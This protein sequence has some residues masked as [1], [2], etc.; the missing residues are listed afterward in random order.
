[1][2]ESSPVDNAPRTES[3]DHTPLRKALVRLLAQL[4]RPCTEAELQ[5]AW[6]GQAD[7]RSEAALERLGERLGLKVRIERIGRSRLADLPTPCLLLG[8]APEEVWLV[9]GRSGQRLILVDPESGEATAHTPRSVT[10]LGRRIALIRPM[11]EQ[12]ARPKGLWEHLGPR[13]WPA[14]TQVGVASV[15]LNLLALATPI[16]MMTVYNK[17]INHAAL[18]TLDVLAIGMLTLFAFEL[19]LRALRAHVASHTG[20]KLD[21]AM[22]G[23]IVHRLLGMSY[24]SLSGSSGVG[25]AERLRQLDQVRSFLTGQLPLLLVDLA[26]VGLFLL[27]LFVIAPTLG[28]I[29]LGAIPL[30][31]LVSLLAYRRQRELTRAHSQA[32]A[33]KSA[34]LHEAFDQALSVKAMGLEPAVERRLERRLVTSAWCAYRASSLTGLIGGSGQTLQSL[35]ALALI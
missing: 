13:F 1:M 30:F 22:G 10:A 23:E 6:P 21:V 17:V 26:F 11:D 5:A 16:F 29:T 12:L 4:D 31:L 7:E 32:A 8:Q 9:R 25:I 34:L 18:A 20:A 14:L 24:R 19:L 27:A 35:T 2:V 33:A 15:V 28:W 3:L